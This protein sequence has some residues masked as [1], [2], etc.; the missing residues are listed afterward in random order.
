MAHL[1]KSS[2]TGHLLKTSTG[3]L[4]K[5][6]GGCA[7]EWGAETCYWVW[8]WS[9]EWWCDGGFV[10]GTPNYDNGN[11]QG[12]LCEPCCIGGLSGCDADGV[13]SEWSLSGVTWNGPNGFYDCDGNANCIEIGIWYIR[14]L[15]YD[16]SGNVQ[17]LI[18]DCWTLQS[19]AEECTC[20]GG[21]SPSGAGDLPPSTFTPDACV[22][23]GTCC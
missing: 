21:D 23:A 8:H 11:F 16:G 3:H 9:A 7:C 4:A 22:C 20:G 17:S 1:K 2:T 19:P 14:S 12:Y 13:V 18:V 5:T 10:A 15:T 6:C